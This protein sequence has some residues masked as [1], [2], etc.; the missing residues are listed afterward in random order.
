MA[1]PSRGEQGADVFTSCDPLSSKSLCS[2]WGKNV[3]GGLDLPLGRQGAQLPEYPGRGP[4]GQ[5]G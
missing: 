5:E 4:D 3:L 2:P 1:P